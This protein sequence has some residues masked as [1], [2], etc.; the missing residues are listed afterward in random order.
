MLPIKSYIQHPELLGIAFLKHFGGWLP[1]RYY[2]QMLFFFEMGKRLNIETPITFSEKL[3][4]LKL[5]DR[6][7][8][9]TIMVDKVKVKDY[10]ASIIGSEYII[11]T[12]GVW[13][14]P[15]E[16]D[17]DS[18][19]VRFVLKTNHSGG[20]TGVVICRDK[21]L[22]DRQKAVDDLN[23]SL[24]NDVYK[25][26]REWPYKNVERKVLAEEF[27]GPTQED[28]DFPDYKFFCFNGEPIYC[29]VITGRKKEMCIDFF[30][31]EWN[32]QPFHEPCNFPF[33]NK[34][35]KKP[36]N[37]EKMWKAAKQLAEGKPFVRVDFYE[38]NNTVLFGEITFYPTS[39][40]GGFSPSE[41]DE[42]LGDL[43]KL[44]KI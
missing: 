31:R 6:K 30:D 28:V 22:F 40:M 10:V 42:K 36:N 43:I 29:Q 18:L 17:W 9:Y 14:K 24:R 12:L 7:Q 8:E 35:L 37:L 1:D 33:A 39:G 16:I 41:W 3:Q 19:P 5:Y 11:P 27:V 20:S 21:S 32:H 4:W 25:N 2:L 15:E 44:P 38:D 23:K 13:D 26:R 34:E